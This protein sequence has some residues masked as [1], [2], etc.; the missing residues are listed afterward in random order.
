MYINVLFLV[1]RADFCQT[2][3]ELTAPT[4]E[5]RTVWATVFFGTAIT[6]WLTIFSDEVGKLRQESYLQVVH[7]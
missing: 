4:G 1:Y 2:I 3:T 5:W 6:L 7:I